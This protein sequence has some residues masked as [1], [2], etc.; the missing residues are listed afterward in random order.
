VRLSRLAAAGPLAAIVAVTAV[1]LLP[2]CHVLHLCGCQA[3]WAGADSACNVK[4]ATGP[5]C[6]WCRYWWLGGAAV[7]ATLAGQ[8]LVYRTARRRRWSRAAA[9]GVSVASL[10]AWL[11][12]AGVL[13]WL[14]TDYPHLLVENARDRLGLPPGPVR[15]LADAQRAAACCAREP[16]R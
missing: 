3:P 5:Q 9:T 10:P 13:T 1:A 16:R 12:A 7:G 2:A 8:G 11:L 15:C 14:P 4:H 6:P